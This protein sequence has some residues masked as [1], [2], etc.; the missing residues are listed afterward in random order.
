MATLLEWVRHLVLLVVLVSFFELLAPKN[1]L[2]PYVRLVGGLVIL[3]AVATPLVELV[4]GEGVWQRA[5]ELAERWSPVSAGPSSAPALAET[6]RRLRNALLAEKLAAYLEEEL[7]QTAGG[8]VRAAVRVEGDGR[9]A[10]VTLVAP[11]GSGEEL[12]R[13]AAALSGVEA[14]QVWVVEE[15]AP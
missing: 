15:A 5:A 13:R 9:V 8:R 1:A 2:R 12:R 14:G 4:R 10:R 6:E 3:A 11:P 7:A